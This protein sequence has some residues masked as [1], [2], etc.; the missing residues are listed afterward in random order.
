[1]RTMLKVNVEMTNLCVLVSVVVVLCWR[2]EVT[3]GIRGVLRLHSEL[4]GLPHVGL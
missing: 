2:T 4:R 3:R 1:M